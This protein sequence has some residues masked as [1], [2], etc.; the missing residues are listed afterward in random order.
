M[1]RNLGLVHLGLDSNISKEQFHA[2]DEEQDL[3]VCL[4]LKG[5]TICRTPDTDTSTLEAPVPSIS[6]LAKVYIFL[7]H[8]PYHKARRY[9]YYASRLITEV[10]LT[11]RRRDVRVWGR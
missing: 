5:A 11:Q 8:V 10:L 2:T 3:N 7:S 9:I 1:L 4:A 6:Q